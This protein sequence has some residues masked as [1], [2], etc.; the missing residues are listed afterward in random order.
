MTSQSGIDPIAAK[1]PLQALLAIEAIRMLVAQYAHHIARGDGGGV[2]QLFTQDGAYR[3]RSG[4][5]GGWSPPWS[6]G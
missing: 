1:D 3:T 6:G 2:S 4:P 5:A